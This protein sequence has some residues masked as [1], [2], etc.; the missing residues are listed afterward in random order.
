MTEI[1]KISSNSY[2]VNDENQNQNQRKEIEIKLEDISILYTTKK[3][4]EDRTTFTESYSQV[5][6]NSTPQ[7]KKFY[8]SLIDN[9]QDLMQRLGLTDEQYDTLACTA[10]A[11]ASQE[12]GMGEEDGYEGE[13]QG[14]G[15]VLR[16]IGKWFSTTF[17]GDGSA[18][19]GLTQM[20]IYDFLNENKLPDELKQIMKDYGISANGQNDNNLFA[21]PDKAAIATMVVLKHINDNY[22]SHKN[23]LDSEHERIGNEIASTPE[24][25]A[26]KLEQGKELLNNILDVY[27]NAPE[28]KKAVLRETFKSWLLAKNGTKL[29]P[30]NDTDPYNEEAQLLYFNVLLSKNGADFKLDGNSLNLL[31]YALTENGSEMNHIEYMAY[32]W[33]KGT[34]GTGMQLDRMLAEK[35]GTLMQNPEDLDYDQFTPNVATMAE[36]YA[37]QSIGQKAAAFMNEVFS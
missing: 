8:D 19:S 22:D 28:N 6:I 35:I 21:N 18:S 14:I 36:R 24:E 7:G 10:L 17:L 3:Q 5:N 37:K 13:N 2:S 11:L 16:D 30:M 31:R 34:T 20:K 9:K 27:K 32:G 1:N 15:K 33:N 29:N 23:T 26:E 25:K 12:T 4:E